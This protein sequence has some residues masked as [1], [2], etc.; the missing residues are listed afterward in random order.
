MFASVIAQAVASALLHENIMTEKLARRGLKV[1]SDYSVD[2]LAHAAVR[3]VMTTE[4]DTLPADA[5]L[6]D[7]NRRLERG[8]HGAY[9]IIDAERHVLA[10]I[11]R[12][13]VLD[14]EATEDR[15]AVEVGSSDVVTVTSDQ[16]LAVALRLL[17][18]EGIG[19]LPVVD[20]GRLVGMCTRTD[21]LRARQRRYEEEA[22]QPGWR[23]PVSRTLRARTRAAKPTL[24]PSPSP[25][26]E[27]SA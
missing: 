8:R 14:T 22:M 5:T 15:P 25:N 26:G 19:H 13:D 3:D 17:L 2:A 6:G 24:T 27:S 1:E 21:I 16:P 20:D 4:V 23:L 18:D 10:I 9:P 11:A 12:E 7:A